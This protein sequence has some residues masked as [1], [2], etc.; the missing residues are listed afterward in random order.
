MVSARCWLPCSSPRSATSVVSPTRSG[1]V[2]AGL[3][4]RH[5]E[6]DNHVARGRITKQGSR[7][8]RWA[9]VEAV[10]GAVRDPQITSVKARIGARRGRNVGRVAAARHLLTL[11][12]YGLRDGHI[13]ALAHQAA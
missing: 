6:S 1:C 12:Y 13:R 10:S 9:A 8:L 5:R 7:L 11:V 3:T 2:R 4:P